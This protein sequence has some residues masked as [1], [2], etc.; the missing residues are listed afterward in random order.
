[1][2]ELIL[3][4]LSLLLP[5]VVAAGRLSCETAAIPTPSLFGASI[6]SISAV[7]VNNSTLAG[8]PVSF[9]NVSL[10]YTHPGERDNINVWV[11]LPDDWSGRFQGVGGGGW[12]TGL[13][14]ASMVKAIVGGYAAVSTDGGHSA[15]ATAESWGLLSPGNVNLYLLQDFASVA[16]ND[17]TVL[18]K[19][20]TEAYYGR[21]IKYSYWNGC[22]TG[23]RQGLMMAQRYPEAYDGILAQSPAINWVDFQYTQCWPQQLMH[24]ANYFPSQCELNAITAAAVEACDELDGLKDG[25][26]GLIGDCH[27][28]AKSAIGKSYSCNGTEGR[29]TRETAALAQSFWNGA[30]S[31]TGKF[32]W[33]GLN[34]QSAFS[35]IANTT[36]GANGTCT[37]VPFQICVD[38][39]Q[40]FIHRDPAFEAFNVTHKQWDIDL[41][42]SRQLYTSIINTADP[43][44][45][46]FR[47]GGGKMIT[48]HGM[49]DPLIFFNGTVDYYQRVLRRDRHAADFYRFFQA[50]GVGHCGGGAGAVPT[51]PLGALI[52]WVES[53][54]APETLP[55]NRTVDGKEW[56]QDLCQYPLSSIYRGGDPSEASSF[57]C[58]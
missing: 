5:V 17:M 53:G 32:E 24:W 56:V 13:V 43:D 52:R 44:L 4:F 10:V 29:V 19:E 22:S 41:H 45:S 1:M 28:K 12:T 7:K 27:F 14:A 48:W 49:A 8:A 38:W 34:Y 40:L 36:C 2:A 46:Q 31:V 39:I 20:I 54:E 47:E 3:V 51:D 35:G 6:S 50:P 37:G 16:L 58:E 55:A 21:R 42:T 18:G 9:C 26:I 33:F 11:W 57:R 15:T 25:V 23:G 30:R